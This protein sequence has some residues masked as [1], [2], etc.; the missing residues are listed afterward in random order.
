MSSTRKIT[1]RKCANQRVPESITAEFIQK[2]QALTG[3]SIKTDYLKGAILDKFVSDDTDPASV[4]RQRAINKWLAAEA[5]NAATN[6]RI[7]TYPAEYQILPRVRF[8]SFVEWTRLLIETTIGEVPPFESLIGSFSGGA[9]TSRNRTESHP[10]MK[11]VGEAHATARAWE[12]FE[13]LLEEIPGWPFNK[14][15]LTIVEGNVMFT[16]PKKTDIDRCAC[17]EPDLN[18]FMQKGLGGEIRRCLKRVGIDLND[19]SINRSHAYEGSKSGLQA[20]LDL[21]SAS[22]SVT[23]S[24][25][26]LLLPT[27]WF[28]LLDA[29]RC[30]NTWIDNELHRNEMFSSMGNGFTF[31]LESLIF[32]ALSKATAYFTG[33][34]GV[35]SVYGDD[36][37]CPTMMAQDLIWIL[38]IFG[39]Q[40]NRD[41]SFTEGP[42]RESCGGHYH[43]GLDVTPFYLRKPIETLL[44]VIHT[45]NSLRKWA[46]QDAYKILDPEVEEIWLWLKGIVP[47]QYWGGRDC[48]LKF[49]LVTPDFPR[50]RL[51]AIT[52]DSETELGG[53]RH[54]L[55][56]TWKRD[57][58]H[59]EGVETSSRQTEC[60]SYRARPNR[61]QVNLLDFLFLSELGE[62]EA[63]K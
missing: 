20:T 40:T 59:E 61:A 56:L 31:E 58:L 26:Y 57:R 32:W 23:S 4:R 14:A 19:Q 42:F 43:N 44:D 50:K 9:S 33:T 16:V 37:I 49:S 27:C 51:Q 29:L 12:I 24:L 53:Y 38:S 5:D 30:E 60:P 21:S 34:P 8:D 63:D 6:D 48:S 55:N 10:A 47:P 54:W 2:I 45:A 18:M 35:I 11:Y 41:K 17:K 39:F 13:D 25:V 7:V 52:I 3:W 46:A 28:T 62:R 36:I 15:D 22:D 1:A